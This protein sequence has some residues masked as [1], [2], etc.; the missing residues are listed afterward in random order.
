[1]VPMKDIPSI[2]RGRRGLADTTPIYGTLGTLGISTPIGPIHG[3]HGIT[4]QY[5]SLV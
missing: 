1:M 4:N 5:L 2:D 3:T